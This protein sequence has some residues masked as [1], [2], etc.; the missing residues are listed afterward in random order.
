MVWCAGGGGG[1]NDARARAAATFGSAR[2]LERAREAHARVS[3]S[4]CLGLIVIVYPQ[5]VVVVGLQ[6]CICY[7]MLYACAVGVFHFNSL[8]GAIDRRNAPHDRANQRISERARGVFE[9]EHSPPL[10]P[11]ALLVFL[12]TAP[13]QY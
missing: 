6:M 12:H 1:G 5:S 11:P 7:S 3:F 9:R 8:G 13:I 10:P 2:E 4:G